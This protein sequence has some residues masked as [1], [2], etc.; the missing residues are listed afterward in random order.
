MPVAVVNLST[1]SVSGALN[2]D[3][4]KYS[5]VHRVTDDIDLLCV[6]VGHSLVSSQS[7]TGRASSVYYACDLLSFVTVKSYTE[8]LSTR[9]A[10][11]WTL[12]NP[13]A[14][15]SAVVLVSI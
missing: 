1:R 4:G 13:T 14:V 8:N 10:E 15:A 9:L 11:L 5:Y 2:Q 3:A 12:A 7:V 6:L